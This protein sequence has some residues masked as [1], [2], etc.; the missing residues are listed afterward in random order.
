MG[1]LEIKAKVIEIGVSFAWDIDIRDVVIES[2]SK[3]VTDTLL[4]LYT[5]PMVV[6]NILTSLAHKFQDFRSIQVSHVK[7]QG[8]K[9]A[10]LLAKH[11]KEIYNID[12]Y[13]IWIEENSFII[14]SVVAHDVLN[15]SSS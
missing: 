12:G 5:S 4:G 3:V 7:R 13:V 14:E 9:L 2:D 11:A 15:L 1:L 6:S 10:H 8:N